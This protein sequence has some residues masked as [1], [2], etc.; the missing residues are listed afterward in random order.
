MLDERDVV[1][2]VR[3]VQLKELRLWVREGWIKPA[4]SDN[5]PAFD[6]LD[7][8]RIRLVCD[9][10]KDMSLPTDAVPVVLSLLDQI[11]GLRRE[12][13]GL[14]QAVD[15][16]PSEIRKAIAAAYRAGASGQD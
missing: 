5:G 1:A 2:M 10:R 11:H 3:R 9:L 14:A 13:R 16:Q 12:L 6:D 8:A 15:T 4:I 7:V